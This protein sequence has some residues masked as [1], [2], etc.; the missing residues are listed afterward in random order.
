[1]PPVLLHPQCCTDNPHNATSNNF[2]YK[3]IPYRVEQEENSRLVLVVNELESD[4]AALRVPTLDEQFMPPVV[5]RSEHDFQTEV[6]NRLLVPYVR[7]AITITRPSTD[8]Q[9]GGWAF[10]GNTWPGNRSGYGKPGVAFVYW[11]GVY[12]ADDD[13]TIR[14]PLEIKLSSMWDSKWR[15]SNSRRLNQQYRQVLSQI[16]YYMD[17]YDCRYGGILTD[18]G[19]VIVERLEKPRDDGSA[20]GKIKVHKL[21]RWGRCHDGLATLDD[22][23][24]KPGRT[25]TSL[26]WITSKLE[27]VRKRVNTIHSFCYLAPPSH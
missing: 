15:T 5:V 8:E 9:E 18:K 21:I 14:F 27:V 20:Y 12:S 17:V 6:T 22:L 23:V 26:T 4:I 11:F 2:T 13:I 3:S 19:S 16:H 24:T 1:M 25:S 10:D 7:K